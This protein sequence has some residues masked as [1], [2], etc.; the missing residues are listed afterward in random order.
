MGG[1]KNKPSFSFL[2]IYN[3]FRSKK[4]G[5][6]HDGYDNGMKNIKIWPSDED[7]GRWAMADPAIDTKAAAFIAHKK[8][9]VFETA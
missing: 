8:K 4:K 2:S 3:I 1:N 9:R 5:V 6:Y 7:A